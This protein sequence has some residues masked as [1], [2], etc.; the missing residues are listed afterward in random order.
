MSARAGVT[1]TTIK[2]IASAAG[3]AEGALYRHYPGKDDLAWDLFK[4]HFTSL[5]LELDALQRKHPTLEAKLEE[6]V[7]A[8]CYG[9]VHE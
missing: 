7:R 8:R 5:A 3:V 4:T 9:S 6:L 1:E 2:D